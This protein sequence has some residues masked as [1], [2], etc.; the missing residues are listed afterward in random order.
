MLKKTLIGAVAVA[1]SCGAAH[2]GENKLTKHEGVGML[3]GAATGAVVGGPI[4][5]LD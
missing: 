1:L 3:T 5:E 2:A 4:G